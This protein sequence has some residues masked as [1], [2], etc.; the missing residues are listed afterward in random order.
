MPI[1][2]PKLPLQ[3]QQRESVRFISGTVTAIRP[4]A[5]SSLGGLEIPDLLEIVVGA[6][7]RTTLLFPQYIRAVAEM[8]V[9][10][11]MPIFF[12]ATL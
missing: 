8:L 1:P 5:T 11:T 4:L 2:P 10:S 3:R 9:Q 6:P 7:F 12:R